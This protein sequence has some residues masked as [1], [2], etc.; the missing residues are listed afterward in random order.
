MMYSFGFGGSDIE[1]LN[2]TRDRSE[3]WYKGGNIIKRF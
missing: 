2:K 3:Y 1:H